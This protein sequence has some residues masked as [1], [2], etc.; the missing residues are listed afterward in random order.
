MNEERNRMDCAE[1]KEIYHDLDRPGALAAC[2][3]EPALEHAEFCS[4]CAALLTE[5]EALDFALR[6][7]A[8]YSAGRQASPR[9]EAAVLQEF[10]REKVRATGRRVQWQ[11]AVLGAAAGIALVIGLAL[12]HRTVPLS[13]GEQAAAKA[14]IAAPAVSVEAAQAVAEVAGNAGASNVAGAAS[15]ASES[16]DE[17]YAGN[18]VPVPY[19][20]D[21]AALEGGAIVRVT[22]PRSALVSFGLPIT[23]GGDADT[24]AADLVVAEDGTP[25]AIRVVP[26]SNANSDF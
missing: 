21:P 4:R 9:V 10:R 7:V 19:A 25:Q 14:D 18:F 20:D 16:G 11:A 23:D 3:R 6:N 15:R 24:V 12:H 2:I 1:F 13:G 5:A 17:E 26:Q 22:L 8:R